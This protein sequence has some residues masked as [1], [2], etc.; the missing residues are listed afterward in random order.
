MGP[1][2]QDDLV[3]AH[4]LLHVALEMLFPGEPI[5]AQEAL[6][7]GL[8][9]RVV[10]EEQREEGGLTEPAGQ[11]RLLLAAGPGPQDCLPPHLP[12][13]GEQPG[14]AGWP[15]GG[16]GLPPEEEA[17]L[18]TPLSSLIRATRGCEPNGQRL[19]PHRPTPSLQI[20]NHRRCL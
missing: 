3:T 10:P 11:S 20:P 16:Q 8:L 4:L 6:L 14:P 7:H 2:L 5:S 18:V 13:H 1:R 12:D 15:G 19:G 9:S 17:R